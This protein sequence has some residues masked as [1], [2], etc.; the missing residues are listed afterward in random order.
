MFG[1]PFCRFL[2]G[3]LLFAALV[4]ARRDLVILCLGVL[5][6]MALARVWSRL[7]LSALRLGSRLSRSKAFP[8]EALSLEL[9]ARNTRLLPL[10]VQVDW[11]PARSPALCPSGTGSVR[12]CGL[13]GHQTVSF[14]WQFSAPARGVYSLGRPDVRVADPLGFFPRDLRGGAEHELVVY[15]RRVP[16]VALAIPRRGF[17]GLPGTDGVVQDPVYI[18]GTRDY[19]HNQPARHIHWNASARHQRLQE[20]VFEPSHQAKVLLLL[21]VGSFAEEGAAAEFERTL[22][23]VG[24]LTLDLD[25]RGCAVGLASDGVTAGGSRVQ[26]PVAGTPQQAPA[27]LDLLARLQRRSTGPLLAALQRD[28][29]PSRGL[30]CVCFSRRPDGLP[31]GVREY[32]R[33]RRIPLLEIV[34]DALDARSSD[35]PAAGGRVYRLAEVMV[36]GAQIP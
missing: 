7:C 32:L 21:D 30:S 6:L 25:R 35:S 16:V 1:I 36:P 33:Q 31:H 17:F 13:L 29:R 14:R 34:A 22:E 5:G 9:A 28:L 24:S 20:K 27:L 12:H 10:W 15:P 8:G 3:M 18:L 19:Q 4:Q 23:V 11:S 26:L 2:L